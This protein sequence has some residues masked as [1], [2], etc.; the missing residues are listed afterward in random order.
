MSK[1]YIIMYHYVRR[2][3]GSRYP[4][5]K[6]L[7]T[8][9]FVKQLD[10][11]TE[12]DFCFIRTEE[13]IASYHEGY[14]LPER[15]VLLTFDDAYSDHYTNV[16]PILKE[17]GIQGSFFVPGEILDQ[18]NVLP[19]NKIHFLL[20]AEA[21]HHM[22]KH[23]L[24]DIL[25]YYRGQN[26]DL[27]A[28]EL[29]LAEFEKPGK[30]DDKETVFIKK[31]L[32]YA[33]PEALRDTILARLF[34]EFVGVKEEALWDELYLKDYQMRLMKKSGMFI[35]A[36]GYHH[37]HLGEAPKE[38]MRKDIEK[39]LDVLGDCI[40]R[41]S[42]VMNYPYGSYNDDVEETVRS[43]GAR[44]AITTAVGINDTEKNDCFRI[45]RL[46]TN[47]FPPLSSRFREYR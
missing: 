11:L 46:N 27:P 8:E 12:N 24:L 23:K 6:G 17:R 20:A 39:G 42:W 15:A 3:R 45:C 13:L 38:E 18:R 28:D 34:E 43:L 16:F 47:D 32:Q 37:Y 21:D 40:D 30:Y 31:M 9:D 2:I 29:L 33:L 1:V 22:L 41:A 7:E 5:I 19:V 35:G 14:K 26:T 4:G 36:H 25:E 44:M 10:F